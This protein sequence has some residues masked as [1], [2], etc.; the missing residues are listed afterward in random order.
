MIQLR[1]FAHCI[2]ILMARAPI[3][4]LLL[5]RT[6]ESARLPARPLFL[7][8][9]CPCRGQVCWMSYAVVSHLC[10]DAHLGSNVQGG[11]SGTGLDHGRKQGYLSGTPAKPF[12]LDGAYRHMPTDASKSCQTRSVRYFRSPKP[13]R[14][15]IDGVVVP[16]KQ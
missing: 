8:G 9:P 3:A 5:Y 6:T 13:P 16:I 2:D 14:G 7:R 4:S 12:N 11:I 10:R 15:L 1:E